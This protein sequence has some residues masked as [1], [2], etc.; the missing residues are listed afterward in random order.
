MPN[1]SHAERWVFQNGRKL[2]PT[3][4]NFVGPL[5]SVEYRSR[6]APDDPPHVATAWRDGTESCTCRGWT[7]L[8]RGKEPWERTCRHVRDIAADHPAAAARRLREESRAADRAREQRRHLYT[9][10]E[11]R[12]GYAEGEAEIL[13]R[14]ADPEYQRGQLARQAEVA[15]RAEREAARVAQRVARIMAPKSEPP[16]PAPKRRIYLDD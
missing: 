14:N 6:S 2:D 13:R 5:H 8:K 1:P 11:Y 9:D 3:T 10:E 15:G 4:G 12:R 7:T 16:K